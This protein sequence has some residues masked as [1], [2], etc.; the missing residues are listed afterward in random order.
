MVHAK[1]PRDDLD[2]RPFRER[3]WEIWSEALYDDIEPEA[4]LVGD[5]FVFDLTDEDAPHYPLEI[6]GD[7]S[8]ARFDPRSQTYPL[9]ATAYE[10]VFGRFLVGVK[11]I[12]GLL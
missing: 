8:Y 9:S 3:S 7:E 5:A 12:L 10:P 11:A 6:V 4:E 1:A 2:R